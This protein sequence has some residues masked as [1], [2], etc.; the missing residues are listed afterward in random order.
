[1]AKKNGKEGKKGKSE[2]RK[3]YDSDFVGRYCGVMVA[4]DPTCIESKDGNPL[5]RF[6]VVAER[7][8]DRFAPMWIEV[9]VGQFNGK[10]AS[11]LQKGDVLH[12]I[13]GALAMRLWGDDN[14]KV[15]ISM[16]FADITIPGTLFAALRE[17]GFDPDGDPNYTEE[18]D[19]K[20]KSNKKDKKKPGKGK[21]APKDDDEDEDDE[22]IEI[23]DDEEE[24][25]SDDEDEE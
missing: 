2:E 14:D 4:T 23:P 11:F 15:A 17:R 6:K 10:A 22:D 25:E 21:P 5:T 24:E 16:E 13:E 18:G 9:N 12:K 3:R 20:K 8:N 7:R 19:T 1:M